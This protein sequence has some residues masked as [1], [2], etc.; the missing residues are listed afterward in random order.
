MLIELTL[1]KGDT[2]AVKIDAAV[3]S[4]TY[5]TYRPGVESLV[6]KSLG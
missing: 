4:F 6:A 1:K 3:M 2:G 5:K